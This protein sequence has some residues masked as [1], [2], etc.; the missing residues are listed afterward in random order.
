MYQYLQ[1]VHFLRHPA[2]RL[3]PFSVDIDMTN[4]CNQ[5]CYYCESADFRAASPGQQS[6]QDYVQ[7]LDRLHSWARDIETAAGTV[8]SVCFSGGGEPTLF[9][10]F[11]QVI[12]HSLNLGFKTSLI[13]NGTNID[14]LQHCDPQRLAWIGVDMDAGSK[15]L[16]EII[17]KTKTRSIFP[18]VLK[19]MTLL[20]AQGVNIDIKVLLN[21]LNCNSAALADIFAMAQDVGARQ[22]YF[23]P[24]VTQGQVFDFRP[25]VD[26]IH[27]LSVRHGMP[28]KLALKKFEPRTYNRCH[29]MYMFAIFCA[30]GHVYTCCENKG[31]KKFDLGSWTDQ[32]FRTLWHSDRHHEIYHSINT[33]LCAPCRSHDHNLALQR[34]MDQPDLEDGLIL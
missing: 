21:H 31:N 15:T 6:V 29:Q 12:D 33:Q 10:G 26:E 7:L 22:L 34:V 27:E 5:D 9:R 1:L 8:N 4:A 30:D 3:V 16:Y 19:S 18:Q 2:Q 28:V 23:R 32:D 11:E 17:R 24:T 13:T 14:R 20:S 25:W